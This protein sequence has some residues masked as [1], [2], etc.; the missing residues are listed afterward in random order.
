LGK[1]RGQ[2]MKIGLERVD[3]AH[4][5]NQSSNQQLDQDALCNRLAISSDTKFIVIFIVISAKAV[6]GSLW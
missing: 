4:Y 5:S 6:T 3:P 2:G 1:Q